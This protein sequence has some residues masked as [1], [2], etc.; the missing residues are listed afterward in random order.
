MDKK[1]LANACFKSGF[2]CS[3]SFFSAFSSDYG[4]EQSQAY[5]V[6]AAFGGGMGRRGATC[7]A[8][9]GAFMVLGLKYGAVGGADKAAREKVYGLVNQFAE[10]FTE[11]NGTLLCNELLGVDIS[12]TSGRDFA[13]REGRFDTLCPKYVGDAAEILEEILSITP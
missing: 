8:V 6:A 9:T 7:G 12:T 13:R 3:Q 4:L 11:R 1:D 5:R 10:K 2:N